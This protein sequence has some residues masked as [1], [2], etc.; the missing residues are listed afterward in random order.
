MI[1]LY[2]CLATTD[3]KPLLRIYIL[4]TLQD[5]A[6]AFRYS[7]LFYININYKQ[8]TI[9][10]AYKYQQLTIDAQVSLICSYVTA[11]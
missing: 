10:A 1:C 8:L 11:L 7:F 9:D 4:Y 6:K 3:G 5:A 2:I